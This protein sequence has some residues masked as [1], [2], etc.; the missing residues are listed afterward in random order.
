MRPGRYYKDRPWLV[1]MR[2][3]RSRCGRSS[4]TTREHHEATKIQLTRPPPPWAAAASHDM[5]CTESFMYTSV[6]NPLPPRL[7]SQFEHHVVA[8]A[9][10]V[11]SVKVHDLRCQTSLRALVHLRHVVQGRQPAAAAPPPGICTYNFVTNT[12]MAYK[13]CGLN[14]T[15]AH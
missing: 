4:S 6:N 12:Q 3:P 10:A 1:R 7:H 15:S 5:Y 14:Q 8:I 9:P 11:K 2:A 13:T